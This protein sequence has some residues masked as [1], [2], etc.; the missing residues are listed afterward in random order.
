MIADLLRLEE[1]EVPV[2]DS[3]FIAHSEAFPSLI[4]LSRSH[5]PHRC[6]SISATTTPTTTTTAAAAS[7]VHSSAAEVG[8]AFE[9]RRHQDESATATMSAEIDRNNASR[10]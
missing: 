8:M 3:M 9:Q 2:Q 6:A 7:P 4:S 10:M 1:G 5:R